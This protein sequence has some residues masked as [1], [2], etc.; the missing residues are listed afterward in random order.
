MD[1]LSHASERALISVEQNVVL[2]IE[3][4]LKK[5]DGSQ[6]TVF[7]F[8]LFTRMASIKSFKLNLKFRPGTFRWSQT[9]IF[10]NINVKEQMESIRL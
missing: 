9:L 4:L 1:R 6:I 8:Q 7:I 2:Q 10:W 5:F 3:N